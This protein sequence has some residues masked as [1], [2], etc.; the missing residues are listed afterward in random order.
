MQIQVGTEVQMYWV[1][2][3]AGL[4]GLKLSQEVK[5]WRQRSD[6]LHPG[7]WPSPGHQCPRPEAPRGPQA[8]PGCE[9]ELQSLLEHTRGRVKAILAHSEIA[10]KALAEE[11]PVGIP[12]LKRVGHTWEQLQDIIEVVEKVEAD[13]SVPFYPAW[14]D[15]E[16]LGYGTAIPASVTSGPNPMETGQGPSCQGR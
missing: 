9:Q 1:D 11:W 6:L 4:Q 15:P 13:Y 3:N 2:L 7:G 10:G 16:N 12:G 14:V 5:G 8:A